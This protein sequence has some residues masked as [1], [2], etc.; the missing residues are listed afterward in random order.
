MGN[1]A[2]QD[3]ACTRRKKRVSRGVEGRSG[4]GDIVNKN[5]IATSHNGDFF[6]GHDKR[7]GNIFD[8]RAFVLDACLRRRVLYALKDIGRKGG[9]KLALIHD[10]LRD[11]FALVKAPCALSFFG[12]GNGDEERVGKCAKKDAVAQFLEECLGERAGAHGGGR[13]A[14]AVFQIVDSCSR[15]RVAKIPC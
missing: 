3:V 1:G 8:A 7:F 15:A 5:D 13:G 12:E 11:E 9:R 14:P 10:A 4:G 2:Q 6:F